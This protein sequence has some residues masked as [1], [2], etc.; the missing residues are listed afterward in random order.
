MLNILETAGTALKTV[1]ARFSEVKNLY[2]TG[3]LLGSDEEGEAIDVNRIST[4]LRSIGINLNEYLTGM[5]GLDDIFIELASKWDSLDTVTQ[6]YIATTAAG[7]RRSF[8]L[9][10]AFC[11]LIIQITKNPL[12]C[13]NIY[14]IFNNQTSVETHDAA[15][16]MTKVW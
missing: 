16:V 12:N 5:K 11:G 7:S 14:K 8:L 4:A 15:R 1:I 9:P 2:S 6:R 13:G 10:T 3:D